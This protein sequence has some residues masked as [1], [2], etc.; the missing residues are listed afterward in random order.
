MGKENLP[1]RWETQIISFVMTIGIRTSLFD[2]I[3]KILLE[4]EQ[5]EYEEVSLKIGAEG[6]FVD[7]FFLSAGCSYGFTSYDFDYTVGAGMKYTIEGITGQI[8]YAFL[9]NEFSGPQ[10]IVEMK[11]KVSV[12]VYF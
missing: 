5:V 10:Y 1:E 7:I 12:S 9:T 6:L 4:G 2:E 8:D 3:L 11:H